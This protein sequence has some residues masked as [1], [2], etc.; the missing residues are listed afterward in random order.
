VQR[1]DLALQELIPDCQRQANGKHKQKNDQRFL[2]K[3]LKVLLA[4]GTVSFASATHQIAASPR[5]RFG[6]F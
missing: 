4:F 6:L 5:E 1:G 2:P 3:A